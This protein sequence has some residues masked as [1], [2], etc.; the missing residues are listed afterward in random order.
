MQRLQFEPA[1]DKTIA[2]QDREQIEKTFASMRPMNDNKGIYL[3]FLREA[4]NHKDDLLVTVLIHNCT[5]EKLSL[6]NVCIAYHQNEK[7]I[8]VDTF[9]LPFEISP[10]T[11][12][13][14]TFIYALPYSSTDLV[15]FHIQRTPES[16][17]S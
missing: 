5:D 17:D 6:K 14:W 15:D 3:T 12:M 13:P 9:N 16:H 2:P 4:I 10:R 7:V 1:W 8:A 11:T